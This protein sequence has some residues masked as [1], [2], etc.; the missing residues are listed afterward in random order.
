MCRT[1]LAGVRKKSLMTGSAV[2]IF[3]SL[4]LKMKLQPNEYTGDL[5]KK[6]ASFFFPEDNLFQAVTSLKTSC[7]LY[8]PENR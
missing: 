6:I 1:H 5:V 2:H 4:L 3:L 7:C 8:T